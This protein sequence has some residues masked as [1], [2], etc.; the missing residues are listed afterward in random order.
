MENQ[1]IDL[2]RETDVDQPMSWACGRPRCMRVVPANL[3][4]VLAQFEEDDALST[5]EA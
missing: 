1:E 3:E 5:A 4:K 2:A